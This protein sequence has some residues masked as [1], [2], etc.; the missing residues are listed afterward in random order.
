M[1]QSGIEGFDRKSL[2]TVDTV[3]KNSL[4][5]KEIIAQVQLQTDRQIDRRIDR[6]MN[7]QT[8]KQ[9]D[10]ETCRYCREEQFAHKG[11]HCSGTITDR[12]TD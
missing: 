11:D 4:P 7:K 5:T 1:F 3:E 12:Q 9:T 2:S 6:Q 8:D 10:R